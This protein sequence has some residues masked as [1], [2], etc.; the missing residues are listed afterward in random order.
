MH[1][2]SYKNMGYLIKVVKII[3]ALIL[4]NNHVQVLPIV[5]IALV[6][7]FNINAMSINH[8]K[9]G[10]FKIMDFSQGVKI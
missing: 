10:K 6:L 8:I 5:A 7:F 2:F 4:L 1:L 9:D 3:L